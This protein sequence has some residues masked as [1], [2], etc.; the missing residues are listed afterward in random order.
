MNSTPVRPK[1]TATMIL[2]PVK[3]STAK[4]GTRISST[5]QRNKATPVR[6]STATTRLQNTMKTSI[7]TKMRSPEK[8]ILAPSVKKS[9]TGTTSKKPAVK[10]GSNVLP[11]SIMSG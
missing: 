9:T 1:T 11:P 3:S 5:V 6:P 4:V 2:S 8:K 7:M 10:V